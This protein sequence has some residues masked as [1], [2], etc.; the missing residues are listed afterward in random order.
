MSGDPFGGLKRSERRSWRRTEALIV[1]E[2]HQRVSEQ[3]EALT[4][5]GIVHTSTSPTGVVI[6]TMPGWQLGLAAV[7]A[8]AEQH[9]R[10]LCRLPSHLAGSGRYGRYWWVAIAADGHGPTPAMMLGTRLRLTPDRSEP[11][12]PLHPSQVPP[13]RFA[14]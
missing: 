9:T 12:L 14:V 2:H 5:T 4:G 1:K 3:L 8:V 7:A 11:R 13:T 10:R 6:M